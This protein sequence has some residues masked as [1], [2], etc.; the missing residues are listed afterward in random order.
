MWMLV[1]EAST[2]PPGQA[3]VRWPNPSGENLAGH[4]TLTLML[5]RKYLYFIPVIYV[6]ITV[7]FSSLSLQTL[8]YCRHLTN[9]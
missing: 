3:P 2:Y 4:L 9:L 1:S 7:N 5:R 6:D 8:I